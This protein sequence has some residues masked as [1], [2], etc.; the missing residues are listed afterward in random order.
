MKIPKGIT[1][2]IAGKEYKNEIPDDFAPLISKAM[3]KIKDKKTA[4][5]VKKDDKSS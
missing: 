5:P 3:D 1:V 2:H 4:K